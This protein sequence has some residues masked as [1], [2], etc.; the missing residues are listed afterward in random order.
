MIC[1]YKHFDS[2][3][4]L[5][6]VGCTKNFYAR[7]AAHNR[8]AWA[9]KVAGIEIIQFSDIKEAKRVERNLIDTLAPVFNNDT[10]VMKNRRITNS[11]LRDIELFDKIR[12]Y[13]KASNVAHAMQF[14][15]LA[16]VSAA[17]VLALIEGHDDVSGQTVARL[18]TAFKNVNWR[19][20]K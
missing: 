16:N 15:V 19:K 13:L 1:V 12:E 10:V 17:L 7:S 11:R 5:L 9:M 20:K 14:A 8:S 3:G 4:R 18:H 2:D 6:Y